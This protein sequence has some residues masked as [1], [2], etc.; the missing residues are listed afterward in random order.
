MHPQYGGEEH[1]Q[2]DRKASPEQEGASNG[3]VG[4]GQIHSHL[5]S[6]PWS[7]QGILKNTTVEI[8]SLSLYICKWTLQPGTGNKTHIFKGVWKFVL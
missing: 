4:A 2:G 6:V 3:V 5:Q 1:T 7:I 8:L